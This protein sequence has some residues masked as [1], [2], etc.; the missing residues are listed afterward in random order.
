[1]IVLLPASIPFLVMDGPPVIVKPS[2]LTTV[3]PIVKEPSFV[4]STFLF[5]SYL[6]TPSAAT[7]AVVLEPFVKFRPLSNL[8][9]WSPVP[10]AL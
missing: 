4:K 7:E 5:K 3:S 8:T 2:L 1:M 9:V 6:T 10:L